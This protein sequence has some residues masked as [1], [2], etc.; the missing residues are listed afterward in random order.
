[1]RAQAGWNAVEEPRGE[2]CDHAMEFFDSAH[3]AVG[4]MPASRQSPPKARVEPSPRDV[5]GAVET[6]QLL[7]HPPLRDL[8]VSY[9][10]S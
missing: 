9:L 2:T 7:L 8:T 3:P 10:I 1:M 5:C 4:G 6:I